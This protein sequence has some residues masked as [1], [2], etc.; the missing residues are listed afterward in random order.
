MTMK[1]W[2]RWK[3]PLLLLF[4][5]LASFGLLIPWLGFYWD[6]WP[7]VWFLNFLGPDGFN[8]VFASDRPLL[9]WLFSLTTPLLGTSPWLWQIF[10]VLTRWAASL[11]FWW[12]MRTAW[13]GQLR[14]AA[15]AAVF[16]TV[17]P[18][19]LQQSISVTYSHVFLIFTLFLL[20]L[21]ASTWA[22]RQPRQRWWLAVFSLLG[23]MYTMF[24]V[25][26]FFGLELIRP[27]LAWLTLRE[28][29]PEVW[30]RFRTVLLAWLPFLAVMAVFLVWRI[31]IQETPRGQVTLLDD[32]AAKPIS[33]VT[34]LARTIFSDVGESAGLAWFR[35]A[36]LTRLSGNST[37]FIALDLLLTALAGAVAVYLFWRS[38][39]VRESGAQ[40][41]S[42]DLLPDP[43]R[44]ATDQS[45]KR[46]PPIAI[47]VGLT[48]LA[49][50]GWPFWATNLPI[51]LRFPWD[52]FT[53]AMMPGASLLMAGVLLILPPNP[54]AGAVIAGLLVGLTVGFHY[55]NAN[56]Y[57]REWSQQKDFFW[58]LT[59]RAPA[60]QPGT[61]LITSEL[62]FVYFSDNSLTAPLNWTYSPGSIET[63]M[64]YSLLALESRLGTTVPS[65]EANQSIE[66][67]YRATEF[68]GSTSRS[69]VLTFTPPGCLHIYDP[70]MDDRWPQKPKFIAEA[71]HLSNPQL[72]IADAAQAQPPGEFFSPQPAPDWCYYYEKAS[73]ARQTGD[74]M[75]AAQFADDALALNARLYDVNAPELAV[76]V[77][78]YGQ[79]ENWEQAVKATRQAVS[80]TSRVNRLLCDTWGRMLSDPTLAPPPDSIKADIDSLLNCS[81]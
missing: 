49:A 1:L 21:G 42:K 16:F 29:I 74:W 73:L 68:R 67:V 77:E 30:R 54:K 19:F 40:A 2:Q 51:D 34:D 31:Q 26:Y 7:S 62:P 18:G 4:T 46:E 75:T 32:L 13:P 63:Q 28:R 61:A 47:L 27:I 6:D 17:Y 12:M 48:A 52:R 81:Q 25:E 24:A 22:I 35:A 5:N 14:L 66:L 20:S 23:S 69:I 10:G 78:A 41:S 15:W 72:I 8:R 65:L 45:S 79:T 58:Q 80:L 43:A 57:R 36:D 3:F 9:G 55:Q 50:C 44:L 76:Y 59:W 64:P 71:M 60:L 38:A 56:L 33:T 37:T 39:Q 53:L 70:A 11:A